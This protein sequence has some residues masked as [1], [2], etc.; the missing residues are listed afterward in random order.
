MPIK[1]TLDP[2]KLQQ[3]QHP[4]HLQEPRSPSLPTSHENNKLRLSLSRTPLPPRDDDRGPPGSE[5]V[6][7]FNKTTEAPVPSPSVPGSRRIPLLSLL[8]GTER[9]CPPSPGH[10]QFKRYIIVRVHQDGLPCVQCGNQQGAAAGERL[11][12]GKI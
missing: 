11:W 9:C 2:R 12:V 1:T 4:L 10:Q 5:A 7:R 6:Q 8:Q 3:R